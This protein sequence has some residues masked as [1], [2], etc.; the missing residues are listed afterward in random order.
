[1]RRI[2]PL[3]LLFAVC[4]HTAWGWPSH[5]ASHLPGP[6]S[7]AAHGALCEEMDRDGTSAQDEHPSENAGAHAACAWCAAHAQ[8]AFAL[9]SPSRCASLAQASADLSPPFLAGT[10]AHQAQAWPFA[11]RDPPALDTL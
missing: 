2:L 10:V 5:M 1:M 7:V 4:F 11:S 8:Q 6:A 3:L 9:T